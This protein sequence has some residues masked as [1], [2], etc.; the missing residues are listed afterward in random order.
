M[1]WKGIYNHLQNSLLSQSASLQLISFHQATR[2][3]ATSSYPQTAVIPCG[4]LIWH[5][6]IFSHVPDYPPF[7]SPICR[8]SHVCMWVNRHTHMHLWMHKFHHFF[9]WTFNTTLDTCG[10]MMSKKSMNTSLL[11]LRVLMGRQQQSQE[12]VMMSSTIKEVQRA[13][14]CLSP[15][16]E[17]W[18]ST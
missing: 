5:H 8:L 7:L 12:M 17:K 9:Q 15:D 6:S 3:Q 2:F 11:V 10:E 18:H 14:G 16:Q 1:P 13:I 4:H